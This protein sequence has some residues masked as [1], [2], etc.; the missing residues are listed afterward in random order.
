M[1]RVNPGL[2][3]TELTAVPIVRVFTSRVGMRRH[4]PRPALTVASGGTHTAQPC[5]THCDCQPAL[6][7]Q[8]SDS[9]EYG[10]PL[11]RS[12][13]YDPRRLPTD[14]VL[15]TF[16]FGGALSTYAHL[17]GIITR[18]PTTL[19]HYSRCGPSTLSTTK[20]I[21]NLRIDRMFDFKAKCRHRP[22]SVDRA[23]Y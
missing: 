20:P 2:A 19:T 16:Q 21:E 3:T 10:P 4:A 18:L 17:P 23:W 14:G 22:M 6:Y 13:R 12:P 5:M 8:R 9:T 1:A 11:R 7:R 15:T